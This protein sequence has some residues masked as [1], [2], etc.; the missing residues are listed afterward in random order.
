M[1]FLQYSAAN[2]PA[3]SKST[4]LL[5]VGDMA[6]AGAAWPKN[7]AVGVSAAANQAKYVCEILNL[8]KNLNCDIKSTRTGLA[9]HADHAGRTATTWQLVCLSI[10]ETSRVGHYQGL[11]CCLTAHL[12][13]HVPADNI[14]PDGTF[15]TIPATYTDATGPGTYYL[16][17]A[18]EGL[19]SATYQ[20]EWVR[21]S[22]G[23]GFVSSDG[24]PGAP[25]M[26]SPRARASA[27]PPTSPSACVQPGIRVCVHWWRRR[28]LCQWSP[29]QVHFPFHDKVPGNAITSQDMVHLQE[30]KKTWH[31]A[32]PFSCFSGQQCQHGG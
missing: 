11:K 1:R 27:P 17:A 10:S 2:L 3:G 15:P 26:C 7:C 14:N 4:Y 22:E 31:V 23:L 16:F 19:S 24:G 18:G 32:V 20:P 13:M 12:R 30:G 21:S 5:N 6:Y 8:E 25:T 28:R 29:E 9:S